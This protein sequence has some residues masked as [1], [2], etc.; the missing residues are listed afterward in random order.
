MRIKRTAIVSVL[1]VILA[2]V[3]C[4]TAAAAVTIPSPTS[5]FYVYDGA[6]IIA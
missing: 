1:A 2:L 6:N 3:T 5:E 4:I